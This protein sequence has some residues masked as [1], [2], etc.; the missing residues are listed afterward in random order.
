M[1]IDDYSK[2]YAAQYGA[3]GGFEPILVAVRR[4]Q[5]LASIARHPHRR[6]LEV[7]CGLE[8]LFRHVSDFERL[9]VVE[10]SREFAA[11][12]RALAAGRVDVAIVEAF[13]EDASLSPAFDFIVVSSLL[14]EV[15]SPERLLASLRTLCGATTVAHFNVPNVRSL[16]RL[17]ALEMGLI[18]DLFEASETEKRFQRH[19]RFDR[20]T[21]CALVEKCGFEV[22]RFGTYF[23]KPFT[24]GQ[25]EQLLA[26]RILP[27]EVV[28]GLDRLT[29][30][31]PE[32]GAEM[33]VEVKRR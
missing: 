1:D 18:A 22:L 14:H 10:P 19:T 6:L 3:G 20:E 7:G 23:I 13:L 16:H 2:K 28:D 25:M 31:L 29:R 24:H 33:F 17:L 15:E 21:L 5:V 11:H 4:R 9:T 30:H 8:P 27:P 26:A 32:H 12:A